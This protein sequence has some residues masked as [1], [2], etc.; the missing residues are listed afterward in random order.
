[1]TRGEYAE[2]ARSY[3][4]GVYAA[5]RLAR[6]GHSYRCNLPIPRPCAPRW[7]S[8]GAAPL[9][10]EA[11]SMARSTGMPT[12]IAQALLAL[13]VAV[14]DTNPAE[15]RACLEESL[16]IGGVLG[17]EQVGEL[18]GAVHLALSASVTG[19]PPS[20]SPGVPSG[21]SNGPAANRGSC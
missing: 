19:A 8:G 2:A 6:R 3:E 9:A 5:R 18:T 20:T 10:E 16:E 11:L 13:G 17:Y 15:A 7:Y 12:A 4:R 14:A 21:I 1:M